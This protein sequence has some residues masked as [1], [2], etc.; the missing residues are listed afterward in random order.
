MSMRVQTIRLSGWRAAAVVL[1]GLAGL[2]ALAALAIVGFFLVVLPAII[3]AAI[4]Y[5]FL[6]RARMPVENSTGDATVID[7]TYEIVPED[8]ERKQL[9]R[10][11]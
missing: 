11:R 5:R 6:P 9:D 3:V 4:A 1:A 7:T 10:P 8:G 2:V